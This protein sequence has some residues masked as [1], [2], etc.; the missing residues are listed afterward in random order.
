[1]TRYVRDSTFAIASSEALDHVIAQADKKCSGSDDDNDEVE[2]EALL[3]SLPAVGGNIHL[4]SGQ[5]YLGDEIDLDGYDGAGL[6]GE[7]KIVTILR[8]TDLSKSILKCDAQTNYVRLKDFQ[9][10]YETGDPTANALD[11]TLNDGNTHWKWHIDNIDVY[12]GGSAYYAMAV[13]WILEWYVANFGSTNGGG[14]LKVYN[15]QAEYTGD[16]TFIR[17]KCHCSKASSVSLLYL[18]ATAAGACCLFNFIS[19]KLH[20]GGSGALAASNYVIDLDYARKNYWYDTHIE[21]AETKIL[22]CTANSAC[23]N[24]FESFDMYISSGTPAITL[25]RTLNY[26]ET[27]FLF[28]NCGFYGAEISSASWSNHFIDCNNYVIKGFAEI[29]DNQKMIDYHPFFEA[30]D[31]FTTTGF[32]SHNANGGVTVATGG[33]TNDSASITKTHVLS[34]RKHSYGGADFSKN[35]YFYARGQFGDSV[36][37][38][39]WYLGVG[40]FSPMTDRHYGF[41]IDSSNRVYGT[42]ADGT[43]EE[44]LDTGFDI[45]TSDNTQFIAYLHAGEGKVTFTIDGVYKGMLSTN[46]PTSTTDASLILNCYVITEEDDAKQ[47]LLNDYEYYL[48]RS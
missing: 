3:A 35:Q 23:Q 41:K 20:F 26:E 8:Q 28:R 33:V 46:V 48:G 44:T 10:L 4:S 37:N 36:A 18:H 31:S 42:V 19:T 7:G 6:I 47:F 30:L 24:I 39:D 12:N 1:M 43:T 11:F 38:V 15:D 25:G 17:G 45:G 21:G 14:W 13:G 9:A 27:G 40:S 34:A 32:V 16:S 2:I 29:T 5:F 22:N